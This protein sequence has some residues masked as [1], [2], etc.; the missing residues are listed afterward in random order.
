MTNG[1]STLPIPRQAPRQPAPVPYRTATRAAA[2]A[3]LVRRRWGFAVAVVLMLATL[4]VH[5]L[6]LALVALEVLSPST[7]GTAP[8]FVGGVGV[9]Q[10]LLLIAV[11][12]IGQLVGGGGTVWRRRFAFT[13]LNALLVVIAATIGWAFLL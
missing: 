9:G 5:L 10:L 12:S 11:A 4:P 8:L 1:L 7:D 13:C 6:G 3:A 2:R